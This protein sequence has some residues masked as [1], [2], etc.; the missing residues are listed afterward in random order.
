MNTAAGIVPLSYTRAKILSLEEN[1]GRFI[2]SKR[3]DIFKS[4]NMSYEAAEML[5]QHSDRAST[6]SNFRFG[7]HT[8]VSYPA[9]KA[10]PPHHE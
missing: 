6:V 2:R 8:W 4:S 3:I 10:Q 5:A 9:K 1:H 7:K